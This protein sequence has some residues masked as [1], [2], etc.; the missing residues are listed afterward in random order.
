MDSE[1]ERSELELEKLRSE[2]AKLEVDTRRAKHALPLDWYKAVLAG[3]GGA[4][5]VIAVMKAFGWL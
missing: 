3:L 2:I 5:A 1:E 4:S